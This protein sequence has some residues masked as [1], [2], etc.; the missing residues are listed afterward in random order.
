[1]NG[2][3]GVMELVQ[4]PRANATAGGVESQQVCICQEQSLC[5]L[6]IH[7]LWRRP[8]YN[9][10]TLHCRLLLEFKD[11]GSL[12]KGHPTQTGMAKENLRER[13][14]GEEEEMSGIGGRNERGGGR[15]ERG[16][17][18]TIEI[19]FHKTI[20]NTKKTIEMLLLWQ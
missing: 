2:E 8:I 4:D 18:K 19:E 7:N 6:Q 5:P 12:L 3:K 14:V 15:K 10:R 1:M 20:A 11:Y 13:E 16:R 9:D 17:E